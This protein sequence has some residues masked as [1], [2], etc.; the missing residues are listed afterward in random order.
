[1]ETFQIKVAT[2]NIEQLALSISRMLAK[3]VQ[4]S[5]FSAFAD[6]WL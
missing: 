2:E 5:R 6:H 4:V 1:L 3:N